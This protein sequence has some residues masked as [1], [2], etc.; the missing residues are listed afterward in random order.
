MLKRRRFRAARIESFAPRG[1]LVASARFFASG[2]K[3]LA[4]NAITYRLFGYK[5]IANGV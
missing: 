3:V 5:P 2:V 1:S 4:F